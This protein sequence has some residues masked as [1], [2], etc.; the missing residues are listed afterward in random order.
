MS[1]THQVDD[2]DLVHSKPVENKGQWEKNLS[3]WYADGSIVLRVKNIL[4]KIHISQ[5]TKASPNMASILCIPDGKDISDETREGTEQF[6]LHVPG[7]IIQEFE[8]FLLWLYRV[9]W[10]PMTDPV[11]K[12]RVFSSLLKVS[13]LWEI[14]VGKVY[15]T[16]N[17]ETMNLPPSR[18]LELARQYGIPGWV[19][20]AVRD[21]FKTKLSMLSAVDLE[22]I[23]L[24]GYCILVQGMERMETE[25]RRTANVEPLMLA[26]PDWRCKKHTVCAA[27][28]KRMW[29]DRIGRKLLHPD[30]PIKT[31][32]IITEVKKFAHKDLDETCKDDMVR[33]IEAN[34]VFVDQRV[35]AGVVAAMLAY[36]NS[37]Q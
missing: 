10:N 25:I 31:H 29:W 11:E 16:T 19:E 6:P 23:T 35:V 9:E 17:L 12:E 1:E 21:I 20:G 22:R 37:L 33:E 13:N 34:I 36:H 3:Y 24:K 8:D 2:N 18:R 15:A 32:E 14:D 5:L 26:D 4:Y 27:A 28:W 7:L 30:T